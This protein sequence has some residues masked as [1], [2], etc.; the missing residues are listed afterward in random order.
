MADPSYRVSLGRSQ[1]S[2]D[3]SRLTL[4]FRLEVGLTDWLTVGAMVPLVRPRTEIAFAFDADSLSADLGPSP[5]VTSPATVSQFLGVFETV[6]SEARSSY[7]GDPGVAEAEAFLSALAQA[8]AHG[9]FFPLSGSGTGDQ[10][11][12]RLDHFRSLFGSLGVNGLPEAVPLA[13]GYLDEEGFQAYL[14]GSSMQAAPLEDWTRIWSLGDVE[15]TASLRLLHGGFRPDSL[16]NLSRFRYQL[17]AGM[18]LRLGT[19]A[20]ADYN[21]FLDQDPGD[22]QTDVEGNVFGLA[23]MGS[24]FGVWGLVRYGIQTEGEVIRRIAAPSES[25]PHRRRLAALNRTPGDYRE[26]DV[27]PRIFLTPAMSFGVRYRHWSKEADSHS[28]Q[29]VD[30]ELLPG[31]DYP[32]AE[33]L[34]LETEES[35]RELGFTATFSSVDAHARGEAALP[36]HVRATYFRPLGGS[37]G[38]TPK[39]GRFEAGITIYRTLWGRQQAAEVRPPLPGN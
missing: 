16:G 36:V 14:A 28:L 39:V 25:L 11:Q 1:A 33:L 20:Q 23:E 30:P 9:T 21:R 4:P 15:L 31:L 27:N 7:P 8:Y 6:L 35:L 29:P 37:G 13:Q 32:P 22:G 2:V 10:L 24:R 3:Q 5:Q 26:L 12:Q 18:L 34:D 38:R 17:G 19:G